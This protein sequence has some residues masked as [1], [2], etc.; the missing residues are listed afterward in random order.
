MDALLGALDEAVG[1]RGT[2]FLLGGEPGIG[3]SRLA[4]EP[5]ARARDRGA[6]VLWA[7]RQRRHSPSW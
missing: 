4:D 6:R 5:A 7:P 3:K 1:G 2:L